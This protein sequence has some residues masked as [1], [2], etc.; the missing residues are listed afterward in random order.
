M[1]AAHRAPVV[2]PPAEMLAAVAADEEE[3]QT[4]DVLADAALFPLLEDRSR[5]NDAEQ[6]YAHVAVA[7]SGNVC[8]D[9]DVDDG[10]YD[11]ARH[12]STSSNTAHRN[13]YTRCTRQVADQCPHSTRAPCIPPKGAARV[14]GA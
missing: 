8:D 1:D 12:P 5:R 4:A 2:F 14:Q 9:D 6:A 10:S 7:V 13:N 3:V 11:S